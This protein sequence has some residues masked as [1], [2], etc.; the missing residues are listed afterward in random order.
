MTKYSGA[1]RTFLFGEPS[2]FFDSFGRIESAEGELKAPLLAFK[3]NLS[4]A[5]QVANVPFQLTQA[6]VLDQRFNQLIIAEKIRARTQVESGEIREE[7]TE[8]V[9]GEIAR[10]RLDGEIKDEE[11]ISHFASHTLQ[12]LDRRLRNQQFADSAQE[13]LRQVLVI[14]WGAFEIFVNDVLRTLLNVRPRL[15]KKMSHHKPYRDL[16]SGKYCWRRWRPTSSI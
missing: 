1:R 2:G 3:A 4:S 13:L 14:C 6:A 5:L 10:A 9:A 11:M 7:D 8:K 15:I 16:L 12:I